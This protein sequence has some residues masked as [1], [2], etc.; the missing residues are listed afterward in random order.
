MVNRR[1]IK[2][3]LGNNFWYLINGQLAYQARSLVY[4]GLEKSSQ[5]EMMGFWLR[6][7]IREMIKNYES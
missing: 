4:N 6:R 1:Q 5:N 7:I 3:Q 2:N